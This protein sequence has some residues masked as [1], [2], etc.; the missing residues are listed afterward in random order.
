MQSARQEPEKNCCTRSRAVKTQSAL[1][2]TA[3]GLSLQQCKVCSWHYSGAG[4]P[5]AQGTCCDV[6]AVFHCRCLFWRWCRHHHSLRYQILDTS[7]HIL[8]QGKVVTTTVSR[9]GNIAHITGLTL[10][11]CV[12]TIGFY[13]LSHVSWSKWSLGCINITDAT[14]VFII[15]R[16]WM[17]Q[18]WLMLGH[19]SG[20]RILLGKVH[21]T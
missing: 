17:S 20:Y 2:N 9:L 5:P 11:W 1:L 12:A 6:S 21:H 19:C 16:R 15:S 10:V 14:V 4:H 3:D 7:S 13:M 8:C 18:L